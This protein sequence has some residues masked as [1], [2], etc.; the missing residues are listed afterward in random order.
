MGERIQ[1]EPRKP[2]RRG[3]LRGDNAIVDGLL[4]QEAARYQ[5]RQGPVQTEV[6]RTPKQEKI[7]QN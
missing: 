2:A 5:Q 1:R 4:R 3:P 7:G 6:D